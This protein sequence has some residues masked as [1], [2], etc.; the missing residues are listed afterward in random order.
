MLQLPDVTLVAV[1]GTDNPERT[2]QSVG[3]AARRATFARALLLSPR[4]P[5]SGVPDGCEWIRIGWLS[6][7][8]Y[9]QY[10]LT[11]LHHH[12]TTS[13]C[14]TVQGDSRIV[15]A[16][17]WDA[18]WLQYDY[19]GAPWRPGHSGTGYRVGN[20]GFCLRSK[21]LLE[22]TAALPNDWIVWRGVRKETCRDDVITCVMYRP[23]LEAKGLRFAPVDVAARFAF[24]SSTPEAPELTDQFGMHDLRPK[25]A[26]RRQ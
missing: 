23:D 12:I 24:E 1:D 21:R 2:A 11:E 17:A 18:T 13:H 9:N 14:L 20:S 25:R 4:P 22:A 26:T 5:V 6:L 10:C 15:N 19:I 8:G 3:D 16:A 7:K